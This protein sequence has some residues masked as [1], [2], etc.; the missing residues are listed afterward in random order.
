MR[1]LT[2]PLI[3][4]LILKK[5]GVEPLLVLGIEWEPGLETLYS[6]RKINGTDEAFPLINSTGGFNTSQVVDGSS[7][8]QNIKIV[9]SDLDTDPAGQGHLEVI[10]NTIDVHKAKAKLYLMVQ[11]VSLADKTLLVQGEINS[12]LEWHEGDRTMKLEIISQVESAEAG[13]SMEDG[14]FPNVPDDLRGRAWPMVFGTVCWEKAVEV[15]SPQKAFLV[16]GQGVPDFTL[17]T[18]LCQATYLTCALKYDP[19]RTQDQK[20]LFPSLAGDPDTGC[21]QFR[22]NFTKQVGCLCP[23]LPAGQ[24]APQVD[25]RDRIDKDCLNQ[26]F[27]EICRLLTRQ[28]QENATVVNPMEL[29]DAESFPQNQQIKI[30]I[31]GVVFT[32]ALNGVLFTWTSVVHPQLDDI[33]N[34][35]C[36]RFQQARYSWQQ[37][38]PENNMQ[39]SSNG[40]TFSDV[41][42][43]LNVSTCNTAKVET[44]RVTGGAGES[45]RY[46]QSMVAADFIWLKPGTEVY[47]E[48]GAEILHIANLFG[49]V[50]T[51]VAAYRRYGDVTLLVNLPTDYYT[52]RS[53][54]YGEY[55]DV[56]EISLT[57]PLTNYKGE[58]WETDIYVQVQSSVGPNP[59]DVIKFLVDKYLASSGITMDPV[60][61]AEVHPKLANY[62]IGT[63]IKDRPSVFDL[64]GDI[65]YQSRCA[66]VVRDGEMV[67][68]YL[69]EE[70]TPIRTLTMDEIIPQSVR[71]THGDTEDL[72][73][74]HQIKWSKTGAG[75][76]KDDDIEFEFPLKF[77]IPRYGTAKVGYDYYTQNTFSTILKS[78]T[79]HLIR[80]A[81][82]WKRIHFS[83]P[84]TQMDLDAFDAIALNI[85]KFPANTTVIIE[86]SQYD[87]ASQT[88]K[89]RCWT[90]VRAGE[91]DAYLWA[92]PAQQAQSEPFPQQVV[93]DGRQGDALNFAVSPPVGHVLSGGQSVTDPG[94]AWAQ[95]IGLP[96]DRAI[97]QTSGDR[98]PSD[99]G[100][101]FPTLDCPPANSDDISI[102]LTDPDF[103]DWKDLANRQDDH[104]E[105]N[106]SGFGGGG[107]DQDTE[108]TVCGEPHSSDVCTYQ[109]DV[110]YI[111]PEAVTTVV[112]PGTSCPGGG[113]CGCGSPGK[114]CYGPTT[115]F[116][117]TFGA[118][119]AAEQFAAQKNAE[120]NAL[121]NN[122]QY[123]CGK[124]DVW[125]A[126][127]FK[128]I[129]GSAGYGECENSSP[130]DP[131]ANGADDGEI[132][133]PTQ[134]S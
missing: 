49:G 121:F 58:E 70:P 67:L 111:T 124:S 106:Q 5:K 7:S 11:G 98:F 113:P 95:V 26:R 28:A 109:V 25:P 1:T 30:N 62:P 85:P 114:P 47:L 76:N 41:G 22:S 86:D 2:L 80:E 74:K 122:C 50:L 6:D 94:R 110:T 88:I 9:L 100:D 120:A 68:I 118:R 18:R 72:K 53:T 32:G 133:A 52:A 61:Y 91:D 4:N 38:A 89:F 64:I 71:I 16:N 15:R 96:Q 54:D 90:P 93:D 102:P 20:I 103:T 126:G 112:N 17:S 12:P 81:C 134:R 36:K 129:P 31:D 79:F 24:C 123:E 119:W 75:N 45:W 97:S 108:E 43:P 117:H 35:R 29:R 125:Q 3:D 83:T 57:K 40:K 92:W 128:A 73:T 13:F 130:G 131:N 69:A 56:R 115:V 84:L 37:S 33:N 46:Y 44:T 99:I 39:A 59:A 101:V 60:S 87:A 116:C 55:N 104:F 23:G 21:I 107:S 42:A 10:Y 63:M 65:A 105:N 8:S 48:E 14:D 27:N 66:A 34:P 78:A 127:N 19:P 77:N 132:S 51:G 82:T